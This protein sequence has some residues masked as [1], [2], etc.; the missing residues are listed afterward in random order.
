MEL[1]KNWKAIALMT[2]IACTTEFHWTIASIFM[3]ENV[4]FQKRFS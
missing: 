3:L 1:G 2:T 4:N